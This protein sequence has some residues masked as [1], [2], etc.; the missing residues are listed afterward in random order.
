MNFTTD[1]YAY[2][3][4]IIQKLYDIFDIKNIEINRDTYDVCGTVHDEFG[5]L[6][7]TVLYKFDVNSY[8]KLNFKHDFWY[9][10]S[11]KDL[12]KD[13]EDGCPV[14]KVVIRLKINIE[15]EWQKLIYNDNN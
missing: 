3:Y 7:Q 6:K 14:D 5:K 12:V 13:F 1:Y 2:E 9:C 8:I 10:I 11:R 4:S 15:K